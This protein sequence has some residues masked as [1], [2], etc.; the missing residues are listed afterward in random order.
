MKRMMG[1]LLY[2]PV[3][4]VAILMLLFAV[5]NRGA[6]TISL[7]PFNPAAPALTFQLPLFLLLF[8]VLMLGVLVGGCASWLKQGRHRRAGRLARIEAERHRAEVE[9]LKAQTK[10]GTP[11]ARVPAI[12]PF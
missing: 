2:V 8:A 5:A 11:P 7:D 6:V 4:L 12:A 1:W 3:V 10:A 9:R